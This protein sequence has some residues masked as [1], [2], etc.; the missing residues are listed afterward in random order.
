MNIDVDAKRLVLRLLVA[1]AP[2]ERVVSG[3]SFRT[4]VSGA[5]EVGNT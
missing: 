1:V 5:S 2:E 4:S 3:D